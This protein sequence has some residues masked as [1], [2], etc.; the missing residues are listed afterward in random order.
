M[1]TRHPGTAPHHLREPAADD[2]REV[3]GYRVVARLGAGGMGRV[4]LAYTPGGRPVALKVVRP[5]LAGDPE[6]RRR[7]AQEVASA[8]RIHG[9]YTAQVVD[10]GTDEP[11]PWLATTYVPGPSLQQAVHTYGPLPVRTVLLLVAGIAEALQEIHRAGVV[12]RDLKPANVLI[13]ADGP[14]V[15]DF[16]IARAADAG[17]LTG[18]GLR[19]GTPAFMAPEQAL[20]RPAG[21]ATDVFALGA[22]AA[23]VAGGVPPFGAGPDSAA[24]YRVV[25]EEADL[26]GVPAELQ[27]LLWHCLAKDPAHRPTTAQVIEAVRGHPAVGGELRFTDDWLP[28]QVTTELRRHADLPVPPDGAPATATAT[29]ATAFD[30]AHTVAAPR[31]PRPPAQAPAEALHPPAA[32]DPQP[33]GRRRAPASGR[34]RGRTVAVAGAALLLGA[35]GAFALLDPYFEDG[36]DADAAAPAEVVAGAPVSTPAATPTPAPPPTA[37]AAGYAAVHTGTELTS[38]DQSY[39]FDVKAGRVVPQET[40]S[41]YVG[42]STTEFYVPESSDAYVMQAGRPGLA[43]CLK[44][45]ESQ[46]VTAL[47]FTALHAGRA[48][49]VRAQDGRDVGIVTVLTASPGEGPVKVSVDYYRRDG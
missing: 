14:R 39:E 49:C 17:A 41:W 28:H 18:A 12:H 31:V 11:M 25:H 35:A 36:E 43:D 26:G 38:P 5:E 1:T 10:S 42:R 34:G 9:L 24:L 8:Q 7:F 46:P 4:Y 22:L 15:I 3:G 21:P 32:Q 2:P 33:R 45:I 19:V 40:A 6:F 44:G 20:G 48:F 29:A 23:Y 16:G 30:A 37:A 27:P 47:P 13:A